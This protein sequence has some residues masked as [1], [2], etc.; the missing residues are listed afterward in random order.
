VENVTFPLDEGLTG[1]IISK[2]KP[3]LIE[4][5]E[6]GE[7]FIPRYNKNEKSNLG[8]RSFLGVPIEAD[9]QVFG[10][11]SLEHRLANKYNENDKKRIKH[12]VDIFSTTFLRSS[13]KKT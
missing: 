1:W 7:Y 3:Y 10:S 2:N 9:D 5:L 13:S 4:D 8:L 12:F 6:K 11:V